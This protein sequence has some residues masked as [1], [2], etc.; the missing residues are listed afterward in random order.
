MSLPY[1]AGS[2]YS[3][4]QDLLIWQEK[5][6]E[7]KIISSES[8]NKMMQ[9]FK[10]SYGFGVSIQPFDG[11]KAITHGGGINGFNT[12]MIYF[13]EDKITIIVLANPIAFGF[14][15][16][17]IGL[18]LAKVIYKKPVVLP[19]DRKAVTLSTDVLTKLTGSYTITV[20]VYYTTQPSNLVITLVDDNLVAK[21]EDQPEIK[22][23][24]ESETIFFSKRPDI[25]VEFLEDEKDQSIQIA[26]T[27]DGDRFIG[28]TN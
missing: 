1:A 18:N 27:Q 11:H 20:N 12:F 21:I 6:F 2:L 24:P 13:P 22:L 8:L 26:W 10:N 17:S 14:V 19:F 3:T 5:L 15:P 28:K 16:Q 23:F 25:K 9:P 4:T 7:R